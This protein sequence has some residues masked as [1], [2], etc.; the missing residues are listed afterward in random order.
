MI[1][2][3]TPTMEEMQKAWSAFSETDAEDICSREFKNFLRVYERQVYNE[4][5]SRIH[6]HLIESGYLF[7]HTAK[8]SEST[9]KGIA[10]NVAEGNWKDWYDFGF[11]SALMEDARFVQSEM[12]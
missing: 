5:L 7:G 6:V 9:V 10:P 12:E 2:A 11:R 1:R 8:W 3:K 4:T